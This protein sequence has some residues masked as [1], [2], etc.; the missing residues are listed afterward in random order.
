MEENEQRDYLQG[1]AVEADSHQRRAQDIQNQMQALQMAE[2][3]MEKTSEALKN[4]KGNQATMF[5]LGSGM[6]IGGELKS[7]DKILVNV[8]ANT[9]MEMDVEG[10]LKFIEDRKKEI[11]DAKEDLIKGMQA[12][13]ARLKDIDNEARRIM[14]SRGPG[15]AGIGGA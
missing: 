7:V 6:F 14:G 9:M 13:A 11:S 1:L 4:L 2:M 8:G 12:L 3:E 5:S 10:A 15:S